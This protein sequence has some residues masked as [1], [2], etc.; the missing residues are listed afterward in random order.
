M[1]SYNQEVVKVVPTEEEVVKKIPVHHEQ[2][3]VFTTEEQAA[4]QVIDHG[5]KHSHYDGTIQAAVVG[6]GWAPEEVE[7]AGWSS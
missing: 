1:H 3:Q 4:P 6:G 7:Y 2:Y 5:H